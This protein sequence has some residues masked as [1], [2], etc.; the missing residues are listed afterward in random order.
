VRHF[1]D[2]YFFTRYFFNK[3]LFNVLGLVVILGV[4]YVM[5]RRDV[6][7]GMVGDPIAASDTTAVQE[8]L[9]TLA[10]AQWQFH[11]EH[12]TYATLEQLANNDQLQ[13]GPVRYGYHFIATASATGFHITAIPLDDDMSDLP[14]FEIDET[15]RI[16]E[17]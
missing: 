1:F 4:G 14:T 17:Q 10:K 2:K 15:L 9:I 12:G 13:G 5:Y 3:H 8:H 11:V 16:T 7:D 6:A